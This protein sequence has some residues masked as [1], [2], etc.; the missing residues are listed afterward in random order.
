MRYYFVAHLSCLLLVAD[1]A[2]VLQFYSTVHSAGLKDGY[3]PFCKHLFIPSSHF[4]SLASLPCAYAPITP[5]NESKLQSTYSARTEKELPVLT[6]FFAKSV[7]RST[8]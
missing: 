8:R 1:F 5:E 6:R 7:Q 4:P 3:A 2:S